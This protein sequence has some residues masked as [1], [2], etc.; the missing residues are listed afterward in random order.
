MGLIIGVAEVFDRHGRIFLR[1]RQARVPEQLLNFA[2]IGAHIEEV[3]SVAVPKSMRMNVLVQV[4]PDGSLAKN[5]PC[6]TRREPSRSPFA[7]SP[8]RNKER[9][10]HH[11][12]MSPD[13]QPGVERKPRLFRDWNDAFFSAFPHDANLSRPQFE[14]TNV[15]RNELTDSNPRAIKQLDERTIPQRHPLGTPFAIS[16]LGRRLARNATIVRD[17]LL[18]IVHREGARQTFLEFGHRQT[19]RRIVSDHTFPNQ[20]SEEGPDRSELSTQCRGTSP[21]VEAREPGSNMVGADA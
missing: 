12:R 19:G 6:L 7:S 16:A 4:R 3:G 11:A 1:R 15:Q 8:K 5:T 2:Q 9:F 18:T 21:T 17:Q 20:P 14:I 13:F 10:T